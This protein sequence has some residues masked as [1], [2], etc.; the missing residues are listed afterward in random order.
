VVQAAAGDRT[1]RRFRTGD[2]GGG[3]PDALVRDRPAARPRVGASTDSLGETLC[4]QYRTDR[5]N[6]PL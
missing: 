3:R 2:A 1:A 5:A 6:A 4:R